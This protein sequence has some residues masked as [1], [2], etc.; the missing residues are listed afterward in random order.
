MFQLIRLVEQFFESDLLNIPS[1]FHQEPL[2]KRI[3][4]ALNIDLIVQHLLSFVTEQNCERLELVS[5]LEAEA[6]MADKASP[7]AP[8]S[9]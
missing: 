6:R 8:P 2:R 7:F 1:L 3:L 5:S 4:F 9:E